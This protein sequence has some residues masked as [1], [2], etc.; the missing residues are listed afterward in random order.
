MVR[1]TNIVAAELHVL[2]PVVS[3]SQWF[4][5][6]KEGFTIAYKSKWESKKNIP[7]LISIYYLNMGKV[8]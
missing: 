4:R 7:N 1:P 3:L 2:V 5:I 8:P 6:A